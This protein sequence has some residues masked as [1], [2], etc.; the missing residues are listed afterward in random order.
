L[1]LTRQETTELLMPDNKGD[2]PPDADKVAVARDQFAEW[3]DRQ[4]RQ[5]R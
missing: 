3:T 2:C 4:K 5:P 1:Q